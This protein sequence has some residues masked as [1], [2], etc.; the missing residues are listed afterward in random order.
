MLTVCAV[1]AG[2]RPAIAVPTSEPGANR[3]ATQETIPKAALLPMYAAE[4]GNAYDPV[5]ADSLYEAHRLLEQYFEV[6]S[7]GERKLLV[8]QLEATKIDPNILGRLCRIRMHWP[9]LAGG[10]VF[11]INQ[12]KGPFDVRYFLGVPK[13]YDR[14]RPWPL[15]I[16]LPGAAA[17]LTTPPP[18]AKQVVDIYTGWIKEELSKH[19]D[20]L[21][22]M[23][24]L[25]LDE[26]YGPSYAG[27]NSVIEPMLDAADRANVDPAQVYMVGHSMAAHAVWNLALHYPTYFAAVNPLA[28][29]ATADWQRLRL[30]N[31]RNVL[32]VV[33]H[34]DDDT[35]IKVGFS[36]SLVTSLRNLKVPV[37][38]DETRGVGHAPTEQIAEDEYQKMRRQVRNLYPPQ[39]W[40]QTD[41]PDIVF[42]RNDWVQI[43][44]E[45]D[46]GK[47]RRLYFRIGTGHMT[48]YTNP[49]S[50]KAEVHGNRIDATAD[51]VDTL[52]FYVNDQMA[53]LAE[54]IT[55]AINRKVKFKGTVKPSAEEMLRDQLFVGRGWRYYT[56]AIDIGLA[57]HPSTALAT[58][59]STR[60]LHKGRILVGPDAEK[61]Q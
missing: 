50:V 27:M 49:C 52:R 11:Y 48:V 13:T 29:G 23:P 16:K 10:G 61:E 24:L 60:P 21:V 26:L 40:L 4:L 7:A 9:A 19:G 41:R 54:P 18:D 33:W 35:V 14:G 37:E 15:V 28:G 31:L 5:L 34:D 1:A 59:P 46:P 38:F 45:D 43:Y 56:A 58:R 25:N 12:K 47:E 20:A 36:K 55:V 53:N 30:M 57:D 6:N 44:Q 51:N 32:P 8:R 39:V 22:L 42:N 3:P 17:F 2:R